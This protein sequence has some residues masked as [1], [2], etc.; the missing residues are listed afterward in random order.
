MDAELVR[1]VRAGIVS[2]DEAFM[3]ANDKKVFESGFGP[4]IQGGSPGGVVP[5]R[6]RGGAV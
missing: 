2:R 3:K 4:P 1:L 6:P 5:V